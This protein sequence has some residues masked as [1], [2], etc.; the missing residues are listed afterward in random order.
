MKKTHVEH[1]FSVCS[2]PPYD[3][4]RVRHLSVG[5][6]SEANPATGLHAN[7]ERNGLRV[8]VE[9]PVELVET[10][11]SFSVQSSFELVAGEIVVAKAE[12]QRVCY[13]YS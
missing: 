2:D 11:F 5:R 4:V 7:G 13:D 12:A 3:H 1:G 8:I 9:V 10:S 6:K